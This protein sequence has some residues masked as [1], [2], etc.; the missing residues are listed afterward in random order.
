MKRLIPLLLLALALGGCASSRGPGAVQ[1]DFGPL[2]DTP[3][4]QAGARLPAVIVPD[5]TGPSWLDTQTMVYRLN[6]SDPLQARPYANSRWSSTPLQLLT[7]RIKARLA[8]SGVKVIGTEDAA[9]GVLLLRIEVDDFSHTFDAGMQNVGS[10][11][12]RASLFNN[13]RFVDQKTFS[14]RT[15]SASADAG[16]GVRALATS[17]DAVADDIMAWISTLPIPPR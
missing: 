16:G 7:Q 2:P 15:P 3:P 5:V 12:L 1:Y 4:T 10:L 14:R 8:Q 9:A 11:T 6:Y 13:H 17:T